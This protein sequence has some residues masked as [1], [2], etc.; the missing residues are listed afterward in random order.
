MPIAQTLP[1][2]S[3][4]DA[5]RQQDEADGQRLKADLVTGIKRRQF[6][7]N[8]AESLILQLAFLNDIHQTGAK[9]RKESGIGHQNQARMN[10]EEYAL[11]RTLNASQLSLRIRRDGCDGGQYQDDRKDK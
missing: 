8:R 2:K 3:G 6:I 10:R 1:V 5:E 9:G 11:Q 4:G 7:E